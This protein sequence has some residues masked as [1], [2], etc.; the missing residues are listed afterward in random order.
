MNTSKDRTWDRER[1][2][3]GVSRGVSAKEENLEAS[4]FDDSFD[5]VI[6]NVPENYMQEESSDNLFGDDDDE[7]LIEAAKIAESQVD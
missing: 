2:R 3:D 7:F 1:L 4:V 6:L 5:D